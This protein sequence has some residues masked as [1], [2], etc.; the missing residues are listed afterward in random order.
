M[1]SGFI[2]DGQ[3]SASSLFSTTHRA[4]VGRL[5]KD[6]NSGVAWQGWRPL[7]AD[8]NQWFQVDFETF[9]KVTSIFTLGLDST[10]Y[11]TR[12][13]LVSFSNDGRNFQDYFEFGKPK[14]RR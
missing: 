8:A 9:A 11:W 4:D 13:F 6:P 3:I 2:F 7:V 14:V 1:E 10:T 12:K 5:N